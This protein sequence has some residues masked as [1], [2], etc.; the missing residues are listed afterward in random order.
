MSV[1]SK[2][3]D[4]AAKLLSKTVT[5][6]GILSGFNK[7]INDLGTFIEVKDETIHHQQATIEGL[8]KSIAEDQDS[9]ERA[10]S[11]KTKLEQLIGE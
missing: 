4:V 1:A 3:K 10:R 9:R 2:T 11:I 6:D 8:A 5:L 7:T